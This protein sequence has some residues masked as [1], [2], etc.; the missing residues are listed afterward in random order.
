MFGNSNLQLT[1][2]IFYGIKV[3]W[4]ASSLQNL[5]VLLLQPLLCCLGRVFWVFWVDA[6]ELNFSLIW[7]Q[8]FHPV[9]LWII[10][11]FT[12][13]LQTG[14]Y[15]CILEQGDLAAG[16]Q[17]FTAQCP[18]FLEIIDKI[19]PCCTGMIP[20]SSHDHWNSRRWDLAWSPKEID[21]YFV[22]LQFPNN[23]TNCCYLLTKLLCGGL[24][25]H[26][27]LV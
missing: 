9:L 4:L 1:P 15:M 24:V 5:N 10:Q 26:S 16:L 14:L 27:T 6:K 8:H 2:E 13:K 17:S 3:W 12:G 20:H 23:C 11:M 22:F 25:A 18:S 21:S 7:P 19:L